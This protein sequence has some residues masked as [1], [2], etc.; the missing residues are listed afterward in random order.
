MGFGGVDGIFGDV[1]LETGVIGIIGVASEGAA[2]V[3]HFM[4]GLPCAGD[5]FADAPH[6]LGVGGDH[7]EDAEVVEDV[8]GGDGFASDAA[9]GEGDVFGDAGVEVMADHQH[10]EMFFDGVDGEGA[11]RV[12][13]GG[14]DVRF[15]GDADDVGGVTAARTFGVVGVDG[16]ARDGA[17]GVFDEAGLVEGIGVDGD[18]DVKLVGDTEARSRWRRGWCPSPRAI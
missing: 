14:Q 9:V 3:L 11:G 5:D 6:C 17:D 16:A 2:L 8:F 18:L 7:G 12:G 13:G 1:A 15:S 10:V 4:G